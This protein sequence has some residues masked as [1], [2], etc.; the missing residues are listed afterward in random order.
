MRQWVL[1]S[2]PNGAATVGDFRMESFFVYDYVEHF[3]AYEAQLAEWIRDGRL[4]PLEDILE[5]LEQMPAALIS[6]Y[7]GTNCGVR[8]VRVDPD[9][10][11][12]RES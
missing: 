12:L 7:E 1:A 4:C 5:G 11:R 3:A 6:L 2:R 9:A 8:M 10:D